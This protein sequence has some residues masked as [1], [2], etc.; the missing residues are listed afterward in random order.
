MSEIK[1]SVA[2]AMIM[3]DGCRREELEQL[4]DSLA[5]AGVKAVF[6]AYNGK[7]T[8]RKFQK[9]VLKKLTDKV[10][11]TVEKF[12]WEDDFAKARQQSFDMVPKDEFE[13]MF[14]IDSDDVL[15]V[16][17]GETLDTMFE[18]LDA[19]TD[20]VMVKYDYAVNPETGVVVV[21]HWRERFM[22]TRVQWRWQ[23]PIHETAVGPK[24][25]QLAKRDQVKI[26]H[27]RTQGDERG[28]RVRN[29]RIIAK[30]IK[31]HPEESRYWFY[32][33]GETLA[34]ADG[35]EWGA[36]KRELLLAAI[37]AYKRYKELVGAVMDDYYIATNRIAEC[38][39]QLGDYIGSIET[40]LEC[41]A[42]YPDWPDAYISAAKS[43]MFLEEWGRMKKFASMALLCPKPITP[44]SMEPLN[45][46]Y[47]PLYLRA[48]ANLELGEYQQSIDDFERAQQIYDEETLQEN[49]AKARERLDESKRAKADERKTLRGTRSDKSIAFFTNTLPFVWHPL[50]DAGAGAERC[51]MQLAPRFAADGWRV[52]IFGTPG[53]HR[54]V[55]EGVEYWD[56]DEF[57]PGEPFK[58]F[59]SSR[60]LQPFQADLNCKASILWMHDVNVG[61]GLLALRD[62]PSVVAGLTNWHM[63][64]LAKLY[65]IASAKL[66]VLPNGVELDRFPTSRVNDTGNAPTF[67]WSS[68]PD[69]GLDNLLAMWPVIRERYP[70]ATLKI[71][72][73]WDIIDRIIMAHRNAG[74]RA[75]G[76]ELMKQQIIDQIEWLGGEEGG[77][78]WCG[79][80]GQD[81]LAKEM[82]QANFWPYPTSFM[83]TFC[84]TAIEMQ[85]AGVIPIASNLAALGESVA[86]KENLVA[87]WP[88]NRDYQVRWLS[89]LDHLITNETQGEILR[90]DARTKGRA[91]AESFT[92]DAAYARWNDLIATLAT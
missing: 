7:M 71:F 68:S 24:G 13:W 46:E 79:R 8:A 59:V 78:F 37:H 40:D 84:I 9:S 91:L 29:R 69:R 11:T 54:G 19:Y 30:A 76:I 74:S 39:R 2:A 75:M 38:Q 35:M 18:S 66:T 88:M 60:A 20:G 42:I 32:F 5:D 73:G 28:A 33:A 23:Y 92:W 4:Y 27:L 55:Y 6:I 1:T 82:Y 15:V 36:E 64:H 10:P 12:E 62:K 89:M 80:V 45:T 65:S 26:R 14:W 43:C 52:V 72:Y 90:L 48:I 3:G 44:A 61:E 83:E 25:L 31:E 63:A 53:P 67:I 87:G 22:R 56:S 41:I 51:V 47:T 57:L 49:L 81:E 17:E 86:T 77:V 21:E 50:E 70:T 85:A 16:E 58:V 34:E